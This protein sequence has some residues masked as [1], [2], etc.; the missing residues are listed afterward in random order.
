MSPRMRRFVSMFDEIG[1]TPRHHPPSRRPSPK[2]S[3]QPLASAF[4]H[5]FLAGMFRYGKH[6]RRVSQRSNSVWLGRRSLPSSSWLSLHTPCRRFSETPKAETAKPPG[7]APG[8]ADPRPPVKIHKGTPVG[9]LEAARKKS[10]GGV[11]R[12]TLLSGLS[13]GVAAVSGAY[14]IDTD[15]QKGKTL[16]EANFYVF[17]FLDQLVVPEIRKLQLYVPAKRE[18][19]TVTQTPS[20]P[21][22]PPPAPTPPSP[23]KTKPS[24]PSPAPAPSPSPPAPSPPQAVKEEKKP[25]A[26]ESQRAE[27]AAKPAAPKADK[28]PPPPPPPPPPPNPMDL[29]P[30][31][32][33]TKVL[34]GDKID[35]AQRQQMAKLIGAASGV[36]AAQREKEQ[37][38]AAM[39]SLV[40]SAAASLAA[41]RE[42]EDLKRT[43]EMFQKMSEEDKVKFGVSELPGLLQRIEKLSEEDKVRL[44]ISELPLLLAN[45]DLLTDEQKEY[46]GLS[47]AA[48]DPAERAATFS[49]HPKRF[50]DWFRKMN[51]QKKEIVRGTAAEEAGGVPPS[52]LEET[53]LHV[54]L[55]TLVD[56][57]KAKLKDLSS[58]EE[59]EGACLELVRD[60]WFSHRYA[61]LWGAETFRRRVEATEA[62][63]LE[64]ANKRVEQERVKAQQQFQIGVER[65]Q[66]HLAKQLEAAE[67]RMQEEFLRRLEFEKEAANNRVDEE[68]HREVLRLTKEAEKREEELLRERAKLMG[69][70]EA[71]DGA[72]HSSTAQLKEQW[73]LSRLYWAAVGLSENLEKG[74][75]AKIPLRVLRELGGEND[76]LFTALSALPP[77]AV[78]KAEWEVPT[79]KLLKNQLHEAIPEVKKEIFTLSEG[80]GWIGKIVGTVWGGMYRVEP[81]PTEARWYKP[82]DK[83]RE[84]LDSLGEVS[85]WTQKGQWQKALEKLDVLGSPEAPA[86]K[87]LKLWEENVRDFLLLQQTAEVVRAESEC[88]NASIGGLQCPLP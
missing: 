83:G 3:P 25:E 31:D 17:E 60:I 70:V 19:P 48:L 58:K 45:F 9:E 53:M 35:E 73:T 4:E 57:Y 81:K 20:P 36:L 63:L 61:S 75:S 86:R 5:F 23:P 47:V 69:S 46:V 24:S 33:R 10:G 6:L 8:P 49:K 76:V 1:I 27:Q 15:P 40:A 72:F 37:Q 29:V 52:V 32:K 62:E 84:L 43:Y 22:S 51:D 42:E 66:E 56:A 82:S 7:S 55:E 74:G 2:P 88:A 71:F 64:S 78:S 13:L 54:P 50:L 28:V 41:Q 38:R 80:W 65:N 59:V 21:P 68:I 30:E 67:A 18:Q 44:G 85:Y 12:L 34:Y 16:R 26:K 79:E 14:L 87:A 11:L 39:E 77:H